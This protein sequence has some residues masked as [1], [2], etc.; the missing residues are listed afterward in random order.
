L[1][2]PNYE[3][4]G[5]TTV[6]ITGATGHAG[7]QIAKRVQVGGFQIRVLLRSS[8][9]FGA[10]QSQGWTPVLG[11]LDRPDTL[12]GSLVGVDMVLHCAARGGPDLAACRTLNVEGTKALASR[13]LDSGVRR[14][15]HISTVSVHGGELPKVVDEETPM[16][17]ADPE[18]Y[19]VTKADGER[20]LGEVRARGLET[21][22]L[23]PGMITNVVRSQWGNEMVE[24]IRTRGWPKDLHPDDMNPWVHTLNLA[25]M[26]WL[27]LN[28]PAAANETFLAVDRNVTLRQF[29]GPVAEALGQPILTPD[30]PPQ[31]S[32]CRLGKIASRLG[33]RPVRSFEETV[34]G[35]VALTRARH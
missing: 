30:R 7:S 18:P 13:A 1:L 29:Y 14:F 19:C 9:Q 15:V 24:R 17:S 22:V 3:R 2:E 4:M 20:A 34:D 35:L 23:R 16:V 32:E 12:D 10:A 28:H 5:M 11:D 27:A 33:Y 25:E 31:V 6:L 26:T 8:E 21:V